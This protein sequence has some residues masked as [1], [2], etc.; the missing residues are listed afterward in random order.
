MSYNSGFCE[1]ECNTCGTVCPTG[2]IRRLPLRE[3]KRTQ[4]GTAKLVKDECI[5]YKEGRDCGACAEV[6]PTRAVYTEER[7]GLFYPETDEPVCIGCG[8]CEH[9]CP[10]TPKSI[11]VET[12]QVHGIAKKKIT[13]R[14]E[15]S[16]RESARSSSNTW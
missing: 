12:K 16:Q 2:A 4:I 1:Y 5:V 6:C 8:A 3:K 10:T 14:A 9:A 13:G 15:S 7:A 11:V